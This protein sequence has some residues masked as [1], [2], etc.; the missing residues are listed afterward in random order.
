[1]L[2]LHW[3]VLGRLGNTGVTLAEVIGQYHARSVVP[4]RRRPLH[5]CDMMADRP[6]WVGTVT[7]PSPPSLLELECHMAQAIGSSSYSWPLSR[8][9]PMLPNMGTEKFVSCSSSRHVSFTFCR[10]A[11]LLGVRSPR[12]TF[13]LSPRHG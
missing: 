2:K 13:V 7:A 6:P 9:L 3:A 12:Q 1:M 10:G 8:L 11:E 4:L 5:L